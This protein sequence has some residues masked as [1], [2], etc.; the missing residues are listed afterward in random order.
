M[1]RLEDDGLSVCY[2]PVAAFVMPRARE[3]EGYAA[4]KHKGNLRVL[5]DASRETVTTHL[6][7]VDRIVATD[8]A[9]SIISQHTKGA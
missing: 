4:E 2:D 9:R 1:A 8:L 5:A 7:Y 3:P 6:R